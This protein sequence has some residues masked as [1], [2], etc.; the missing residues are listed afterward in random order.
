MG[1]QIVVGD[2][3]AEDDERGYL[4][5]NTGHHEIVA[6]LLHVAAAVGSGCDATTRSLKDQGEEIAQ[7]ED[8]GVQAGLE[9]R[10]RGACFENDVLKGDVDA[11]GDE[12][13][14]D[15]ETADLDVKT[16]S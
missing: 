13:R 2:Q 3:S 5:N 1:A 6:D 7:N 11:S 14:G 4:P 10:E 15:D 12:G 8:P 16:I 9:A